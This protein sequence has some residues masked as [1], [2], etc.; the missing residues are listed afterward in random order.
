MAPDDQHSDVHTSEELRQKFL[1]ELDLLDT[2]VQKLKD[3]TDRKI[4]L[5]IKYDPSPWTLE[6]VPATSELHLEPQISRLSTKDT[7]QILVE[8]LPITS[9]STLRI[10]AE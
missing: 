3:Q 7:F 1:Y 9:S 10:F 8:T 4:A 2:E 6:K 5:T